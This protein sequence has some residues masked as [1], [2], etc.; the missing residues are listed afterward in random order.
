MLSVSSKEKSISI[1]RLIEKLTSEQ[2]VGLF[3]MGRGESVVGLADL[4]PSK[5]AHAKTA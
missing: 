5:I 2:K 3:L 4:T 1:I